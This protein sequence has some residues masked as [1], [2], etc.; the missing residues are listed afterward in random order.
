[1]VSGCTIVLDEWYTMIIYSA[2]VTTLS[3]MYDLIKEKGR[4]KERICR[5]HEGWRGQAGWMIAVRCGLVEIESGINYLSIVS[6][7]TT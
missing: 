2:N 6:A 1:M 4:E 3:R 7:T 5:W